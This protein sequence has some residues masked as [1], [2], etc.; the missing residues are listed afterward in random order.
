MP[1]LVDTQFGGTA[2]TVLYASENAVH[3]VLVALEL[4]HGVHDVLQDLGTCQGTL[5]GDVTDEQDAHS[6]RLG[7]AQEGRGTLPNLRERTGT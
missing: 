7:I 3:V 1:H 2:E 5:L 4:K 6:A